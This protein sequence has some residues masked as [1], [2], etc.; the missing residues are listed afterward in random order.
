VLAVLPRIGASASAHAE[1][2]GTDETGPFGV[3]MVR[4]EGVAEDLKTAT[5]ARRR[6]TECEGDLPRPPM[7]LP[8]LSAK[9]HVVR[10][11]LRYEE[12]I[13]AYQSRGEQVLIGIFRFV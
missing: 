8:L 3:L 1:L 6:G 10:M 4:S 2:R 9:V 7:G 5:S 12:K 13:V 11:L